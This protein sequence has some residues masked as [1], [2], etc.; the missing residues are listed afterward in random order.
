VITDTTP[1]MRINREEVF[2]PVISVAPYDTFA[3]A[4][5]MANAGDFGLQVGVFTQNINR[6]CGHSAPWKSGALW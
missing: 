3:E 5:Q 2:A 4:L 6:L 1:D